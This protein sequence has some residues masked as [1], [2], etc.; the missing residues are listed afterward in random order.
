M[1]IYHDVLTSMVPNVMLDLA[2][3]W[4]EKELKDVKV[5][6]AIVGLVM[7]TALAIRPDISFAVTA[8]CRYNS[9]PFSNHLTSAKRVLQY[10]NSTAN[11]RLHFSTSCNTGSNNQLSGYMDSDWANDS[12]NRKSPGCEVFLLSNG[13]ISWH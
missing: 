4:G 11:L 5:Y 1:Q 2:E 8:L 13:A 10:L 9:H 12:A 6:Q 7:Y 3:D